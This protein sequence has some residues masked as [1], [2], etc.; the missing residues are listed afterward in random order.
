[1]SNLSLE[2]F[3]NGVKVY[4]DNDL[5]KFTSDAIKLAKFCNIKHTDNVLDMCAGCG[6]VG[7]YSYSIVECNKI[8]F[9]E[10]QPEMCEL[11]NKNISLNGLA[12]KAVVLNKDLNDLIPNDFDK[13]LDVIMCNP[14]YF[15]VN[16]KIKADEKVAMCRHEIKTTLS[17]IVAKASMLIKNAGKFYIIIPADRLAECVVLLNRFGFEVKNMQIFCSKEDATVCVLENVKTGKSGLK[18]KIKKENG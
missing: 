10:I 18:I 17:Q 11:I 9:N 14:P 16:G 1:M 4:Q 12:E 5:Y 2:H 7:F 6:V 8:Y 3:E 15:K 13:P